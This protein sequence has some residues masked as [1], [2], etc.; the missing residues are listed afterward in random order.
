VI[1]TFITLIY[2]QLNRAIDAQT[3]D[4][5]RDELVRSTVKEALLGCIYDW[6]TRCNVWLSVSNKD[7]MLRDYAGMLIAVCS[8]FRAR[9]LLN[10]TICDPILGFAKEMQ[11]IA[12]YEESLEENKYTDRAPAVFEKMNEFYKGFDRLYNKEML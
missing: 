4:D 5:E 3:K 9:D 1:E 11:A 10:E 2:Q 7:E 12:D 8:K 6:N